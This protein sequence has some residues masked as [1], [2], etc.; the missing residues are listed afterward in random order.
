MLMDWDNFFRDQREKL[1]ICSIFRL[2]EQDEQIEAQWMSKGVNLG[3][4]FQ[5]DLEKSYPSP[6]TCIFLKIIHGL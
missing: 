6:L 5:A 2:I 4:N 1:L 3:T